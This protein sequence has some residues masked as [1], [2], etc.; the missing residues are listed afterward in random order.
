MEGVV[1]RNSDQMRVVS[2]L[3]TVRARMVI[4]TQQWETKPVT[5][6][7]HEA[8]LLATGMSAV[9]LGELDTARK[10]ADRHTGL[11]SVWRSATRRL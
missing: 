11:G 10:A 4:E 1:D 2:A 3:P 5:E 6:T 7:S 8:E 9:N